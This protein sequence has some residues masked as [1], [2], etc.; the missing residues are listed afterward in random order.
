MQ[1]LH[2]H[3]FNMNTIHNLDEHVYSRLL[4]NSDL[5]IPIVILSSF[6]NP[7]NGTC[8][9]NALEHHLILQP[10][11]S[12]GQLVVIVSTVLW[13][14]HKLA[15]IPCVVAAF[16]SLEN[17]FTCNMASHQYSKIFVAHR[18]WETCSVVSHMKIQKKVL[19][20][21]G[22]SKVHCAI[23]LCSFI[24]LN[25]SS[26]GKHWPSS[27][28][29]STGNNA[30]WYV[31]KVRIGLWWESSALH[32]EWS[33]YRL[34]MHNAQGEFFFFSKTTSI[35]FNTVMFL[36]WLRWLNSRAEK[37]IEIQLASGLEHFS[38]Q[39]PPLKYYL[40]H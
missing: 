37:K 9:C 28:C 4:G 19:C 25:R 38:F 30:S 2:V 7:Q 23:L 5:S 20:R 13:L 6:S 1:L 26:D 15:V 35:T 16:F 34:C 27:A 33:M 17:T 11:R 32:Y 8:T 18:V 22:H 36:L 39:L 31:Q 14:Q 29:S 24:I 21:H 3:N 12:H 10:P 40:P